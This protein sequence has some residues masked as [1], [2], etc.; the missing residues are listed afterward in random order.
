M[1]INYFY[2]SYAI[3]LP[4]FLR[5]FLVLSY[6]PIFNVI[7][8]V[9]N[10]SLNGMGGSLFVD[11][12]F[13]NALTSLMCPLSWFHKCI[14]VKFFQPYPFNVLKLLSC[15]TLPPQKNISIQAAN[16]SFSSSKARSIYSAPRRW[17]VF[18]HRDTCEHIWHRRARNGVKL[19]KRCL[20]PVYSKWRSAIDFLSNVPLM[21]SLC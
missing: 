7:I 8:V 21:R 2:C 4:V 6:S 9:S 10:I 14:L 11:T 18:S 15:R 20:S 13:I 16:L 3:K 1:K 12:A 5:I 19:S 17:A